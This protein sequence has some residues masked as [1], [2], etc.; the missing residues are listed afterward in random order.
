MFGRRIRFRIWD[1]SK[2]VYLDE[3]VECELSY[4]KT[5]GWCLWNIWCVPHKLMCGEYEEKRIVMM[6]YI[7][8]KDENGKMI[9]EGDIVE[10]RW[11]YDEYDEYRKG[12]VVYD[13]KSCKYVVVCIYGN[14][15]YDF[16][17]DE[18]C[19]LKVLG[20]VFEHG[21]EYLGYSYRELEEVLRSE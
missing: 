9:Y 12:V 8:K 20:N 1:G 19:K 11:F 6:E 17:F 13:D 15:I 3:R 7:G 14:E 5:G 16:P 18:V 2:M 10:F 4:T 21:K